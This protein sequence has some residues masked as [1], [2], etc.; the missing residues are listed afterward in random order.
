MPSD[1]PMNS[2]KPGRRLGQVKA[3]RAKLG[4]VPPMFLTVKLRKAIDR[5]LPAGHHQRLRQYFDSYG[6]LRC[7][8]SN[9][10]Y[11]ANGFCRLCISMLGKRMRKVDKKRSE[12]H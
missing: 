11:S 5:L 4:S 10:L 6:C 8:R 1:K 12:E 3:V 2:R 7:S 9:V